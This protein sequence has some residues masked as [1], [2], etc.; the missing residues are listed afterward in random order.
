MGD[1]VVMVT[2]VAGADDDMVVLKGRAQL[3]DV[4]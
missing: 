2:E 3:E 4:L 1:A